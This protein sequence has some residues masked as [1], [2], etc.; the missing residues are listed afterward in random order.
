MILEPKHKNFKGPYK[1]KGQFENILYQEP[2][3]NTKAFWMVLL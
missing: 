1:L 2:H 3:V